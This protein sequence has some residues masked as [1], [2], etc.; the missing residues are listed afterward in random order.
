QNHRLIL[1]MPEGAGFAPA[2]PLPPLL[3]QDQHQLAQAQHQLA[4]GQHK[5]AQAVDQLAGAVHQMARA[6]SVQAAQRAADS[7][8]L[9]VD[10]GI[11]LA[12][13]AVLALL[14]GGLIAGR[15]LRPIRTI[16]RKARRISS[17]SLHE[18]LALEG[19]QDELKELGDTLDDLL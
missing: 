16:T 14:T 9:L 4:Q 13:V 8:Q 15:M 3:A 2:R 5:L 7:H 17:T 12:I 19:P 6:G 10:S 11:A 1:A 18:R